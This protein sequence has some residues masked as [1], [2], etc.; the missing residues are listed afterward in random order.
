MNWAKEAQ[1]LPTLKKVTNYDLLT[2]LFIYYGDI[3]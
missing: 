2:Y 1:I 3:G